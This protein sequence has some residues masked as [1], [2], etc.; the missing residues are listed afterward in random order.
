MQLLQSIVVSTSQN[1]LTVLAAIDLILTV[2]VIGIT[3]AL[4][5]LRADIRTITP[6]YTLEMV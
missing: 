2:F 3:I 6:S 1:I 4:L 5:R